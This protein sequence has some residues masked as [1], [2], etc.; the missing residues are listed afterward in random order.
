MGGR[1]GTKGLIVIV[2][3]RMERLDSGAVD[4]ILIRQY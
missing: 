1:G 4:E 3:V 2:M